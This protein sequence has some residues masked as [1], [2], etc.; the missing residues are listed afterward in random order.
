MRAAAGILCGVLLASCEESAPPKPLSAC[1]RERQDEMARC[2][3]YLA[4]GYR[5]M[6]AL[7]M[8]QANHECPEDKR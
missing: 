4:I 1:E 3:L 6:W 2:G 7:C 8:N 5:M